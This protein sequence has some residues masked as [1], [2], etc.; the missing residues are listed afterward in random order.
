MDYSKNKT[1]FF[2]IFLFFIRIIPASADT[3]DVLA[4]L[5]VS[6]MVISAELDVPE[7]RLAVKDRQLE[8][9]MNTAL[10]AKGYRITNQAEITVT[11]SVIEKREHFLWERAYKLI[12]IKV[13]AKKNGQI[14][15]HGGKFG[16]I[17]ELIHSPWA[18]PVRIAIVIILWPLVIR[19]CP[20]LLDIGLERRRYFIMVWVVVILAL[21]LSYL[22]S[23]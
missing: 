9:A 18:I 8:T 14:I 16:P 2:I 15:W 6:R 12:T 13:F 3:L 10:G 5:A 21:A 11:G 19:I 4:E 1:V 22:W 7:L 17:K 23:T 20:S